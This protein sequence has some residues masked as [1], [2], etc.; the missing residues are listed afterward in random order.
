MSGQAAHDAVDVADPPA[1]NRVPGD[2]HPVNG[3]HAQGGPT[4]VEDDGKRRLLDETEPQ[5]IRVKVRAR[6][7][8]VVPMN[9]TSAAV[10]ST[11]RPP[12]PQGH[13]RVARSGGAPGAD[14]GTFAAT[15]TT[16]GR[17]ASFVVGAFDDH[18]QLRPGAA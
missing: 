9:A 10:P 15:A 18:P 11:V 4:G 17:W 14:P 6:A 1:E 12:L 2:D 7:M 8:S 3:G 16:S 5:D 13:G